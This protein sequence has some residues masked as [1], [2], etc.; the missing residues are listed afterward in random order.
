MWVN[1]TPITAIYTG[2]SKLVIVGCK[3][4]IWVAP[5][6]TTRGPPVLFVSTWLHVTIE[7]STIVSLL[8]IPRIHQLG[9]INSSPLCESSRSYRLAHRL[10]WG[11]HIE[12]LIQFL[13]VLTKCYESVLMAIYIHIYQYNHI[14]IYILVWLSNPVL[15]FLT[16]PRENMGP[17]NGLKFIPYICLELLRSNGSLIDWN[18]LTVYG[19]G[20]TL[21]GRLRQQP[22]YTS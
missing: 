2:Y 15:Y 10:L 8:G 12:C 1:I 4:I 13:Q 6:C 3:R 5:P 17:E 9:I 21:G 20:K 18:P 16:S 22:P 19:N 14:Y 11:T 7:T